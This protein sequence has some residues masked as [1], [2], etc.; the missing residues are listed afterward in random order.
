[1]IHHSE[2]SSDISH[3]VRW[4]D[5]LDGL[6]FLEIGTDSRLVYDLSKELDLGLGKPTSL[7]VQGKSCLL[8][9]VEDCN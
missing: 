8:K 4:S 6:D 3:I 1:M 5:T 2:E 7:L 9:S